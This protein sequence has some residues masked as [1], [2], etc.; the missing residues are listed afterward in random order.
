MRETT[1]YIR[2][3][4]SLIELNNTLEYVADSILKLLESVNSYLQGVRCALSKQ[5]EVLEEELR[6]AEEN[7]AHAE[8]VYGSCL[9]SQR[10]VEEK[11][12]D[13]NSCGGY[14]TPSCDGEASEV[15]R[16]KHERD[17]CQERYDA[18]KRICDECE[19]EIAKYK[20]TGGFVISPG[21][22]KTLENLAKDHTNKATS[23]MREILDVVEEYLRLNMSIRYNTASNVVVDVEIKERGNDQALSPAQKEERHATANQNVIRRQREENS[24]SR[25]IADA[26]RVIRCPKCNRSVVGCICETRESEYKREQINVINSNDFLR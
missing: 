9:A 12:E 15:E 18:G 5:L 13:G 14:Y 25:Q 22:E 16:C 10:W 3:Y 1:A 21:G 17:R 24:G 11:D 4:Q 2:D 23:K 7:L 20:E 8:S 19:D 6:Q 26:N